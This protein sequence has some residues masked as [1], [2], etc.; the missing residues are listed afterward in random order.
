MFVDKSVHVYYHQD[1]YHACALHVVVHSV[2][3]NKPAHAKI[4][5]DLLIYLLFILYVE[6]SD[7]IAQECKWGLQGHM[8][9]IAEY[10]KS[11]CGLC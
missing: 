5:C 11:Q 3:H 1:C 4:M 8:Q 7:S 10:K 9:P 2:R 6:R